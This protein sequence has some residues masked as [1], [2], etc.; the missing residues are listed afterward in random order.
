LHGEAFFQ[1]LV[2]SKFCT[3]SNSISIKHAGIDT[4]CCL[5]PD[6]TKDSATGWEGCYETRKNKQTTTNKTAKPPASQAN[7]GVKERRRGKL[8]LI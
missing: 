7:G 1:A 6:T 8:D 3:L 2:I 5:C 4:R